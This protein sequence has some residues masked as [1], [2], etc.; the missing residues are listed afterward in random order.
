MKLLV[1]TRG[2]CWAVAGQDRHFA[3]Q[4]HGVELNHP[5]GL[6]VDGT[7]PSA[8]MCPSPSRVR[9]R[10][11]TAPSRSEDALIRGGH[12]GTRCMTRLTVTGNECRRRVVAVPQRKHPHID[13][14]SLPFL[15]KS[16]AYCLHIRIKPTQIAGIF[17]NLLVAFKRNSVYDL[18]G[19]GITWGRGSRG[20]GRGR[21]GVASL[22]G[23][24]VAP[25][26]YASGLQGVA[27]ELRE[28]VNIL[29]ERN[30]VGTLTGVGPPPGTLDSD[31]QGDEEEGTSTRRPPRSLY[32][33]LI[34]YVRQAWT[35]VK[36]ALGTFDFDFAD[37]EYEEEQTPRYR[38]DS[39]ASLCRATRFTEA[40][41]KR[42]Y[43]SFKAECPTGVVR[44]ET[45]KCI[46]S[47]FFPQGA[48][49]SGRK[50]CPVATWFRCLVGIYLHQEVVKLGDTTGQS[51]QQLKPQIAISQTL[52]VFNIYN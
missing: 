22:L 36:F 26:N 35:G 13:Q 31:G 3:S 44:E 43:R 42:I 19:S 24:G 2:P 49:T 1:S 30:Q 41:L 46:Y 38:P 33:R 23:S 10:Q 5:C 15:G 20:R 16:R 45:F 32:R 34:N 11:R 6:T 4:P 12:P 48:E 52:K 40:E 7:S 29:G 21:G 14:S 50:P 17:A 8:S 27:P 51:L 9:L 28:V 47:Q 18:E 39:L 25:A 37:S